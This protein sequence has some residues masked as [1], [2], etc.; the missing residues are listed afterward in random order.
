MSEM[1]LD[2][3]NSLHASRAG[4]A[5]DIMLVP[6]DKERSRANTHSSG[7]FSRFSA[8]LWIGDGSAPPCAVRECDSLSLPGLH[9]DKA[10]A[11]GVPD[12]VDG[13]LEPELVEDV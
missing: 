6:N 2:S 1:R 13:R 11:C 10:D 7:T 3:H 9:V 12:Q 4:N 5:K 8:S